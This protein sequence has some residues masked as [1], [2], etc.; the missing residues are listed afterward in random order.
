[1][2][3]LFV[4]ER[5]NSYQTIQNRKGTPAF[6][7]VEVSNILFLCGKKIAESPLYDKPSIHKQYAHWLLKDAQES[8]YIVPVVNPHT[9]LGIAIGNCHGKSFKIH[10]CTSLPVPAAGSRAFKMTASSVGASE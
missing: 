7:I 2:W 5:E 8:R 9:A 10:P 4:A 3:A 1:M 6:P